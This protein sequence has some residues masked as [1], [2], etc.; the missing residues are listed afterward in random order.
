MEAEV[1]DQC[2]TMLVAGFETTARL[3]FW[4]TYLLTLDIAEQNRI[5][6]EVAAFSPER[7]RSLDD[8]RNWPRLR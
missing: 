1:R 7:V 4:A 8:L 5:R 2:S 6:V 3:L